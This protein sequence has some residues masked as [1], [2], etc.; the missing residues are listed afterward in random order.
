[1][2]GH[3]PSGPF[4][5]REINEDENYERLR[6]E[7][8]GTVSEFSLTDTS[9]NGHGKGQVNWA[10]QNDPA[11]MNSNPGIG[12]PV[13][14]STN[15]I[16]P[17]VEEEKGKTHTIILDISTV[18]FVD[19]ATSNTLK[20]V[21]VCSYVKIWYFVM[22]PLWSL[23]Y[24]WVKWTHF[25]NERDANKQSFYF[26]QIFMEY[27]QVNYDIYLAGV[28]GEWDTKQNRDKVNVINADSWH[29]SFSLYVKVSVLVAPHCSLSDMSV[30]HKYL[31]L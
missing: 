10:Y 25:I 19:T 20:N 27:E 1:M 18:S 4:S 13:D 2:L 16:P 22:W 11:I 28:Q 24:S 21:C 17:P 8:Q 5:F 9:A 3:L 29:W 30:K 26:L 7:S 23:V 15:P 14:D 12:C 6:R 31:F